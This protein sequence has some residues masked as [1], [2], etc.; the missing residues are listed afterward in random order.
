MAASDAP[1]FFESSFWYGSDPV[2]G[3]GGWGDPN[4]DWEVPDGAFSTI[5]V[6]YPVPHIV[7]REYTYQPFDSNDPL[8]LQPL[9]VGNASFSA[10]VIQAILGTAAGDYKGFQTMLE[11]VEVRA[12]ICCMG[13]LIPML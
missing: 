13:F 10:S 11:A 8:F 6:A 7:R 1:D 5:E 3:L 2:S 4:S 9:L 12:W